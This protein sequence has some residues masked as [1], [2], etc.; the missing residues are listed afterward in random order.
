MVYCPSNFYRKKF[1]LSE[2]DVATLMFYYAPD[3]DK[4]LTELTPHVSP[5]DLTELQGIVVELSNR[6][7]RFHRSS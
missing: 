4:L 6:M 5:T 3:M 7:K 1:T 2:N